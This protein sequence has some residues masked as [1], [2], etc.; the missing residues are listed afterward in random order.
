MRSFV[1]RTLLFV[2]L[3]GACFAQSATTQIADKART[4]GSASP[5]VLLRSYDPNRPPENLRPD[6]QGAYSFE[7]EQLDRFELKVGAVEGYQ[8]VNGTRT[9]LPVGSSIKNGSFYWQLGPA[10]LGEFH[11]VLLQ[12]GSVPVQVNVKVVPQSFSQK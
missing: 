7:V 9:P 12:A 1:S 2:T 5:V 11:L 4:A 8:M 10:F 3:A 6:Q